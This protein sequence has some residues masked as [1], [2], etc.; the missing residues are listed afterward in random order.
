MKVFVPAYLMVNRTAGS[1][2]SPRPITGDD[3]QR[4]LNLF[5]AEVY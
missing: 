2:R 5:G 1:R 3:R 4:D